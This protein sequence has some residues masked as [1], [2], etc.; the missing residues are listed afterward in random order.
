MR[1]LYVDPEDRGL[2]QLTHAGGRYWF[3]GSL[4]VGSAH[5]GAGI[6]QSLM[7][8]V[9]ADADREDVALALVIEPDPRPGTL[10]AGA[11]FAWY[12]RLG[13]EPVDGRGGAMV[14]EPVRSVAAP[15]RV[16][17]HA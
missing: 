8:R 2:V 15:A 1:N 7:K 11:L 9:C 3:I 14:R 4:R 12:R 10:S 16:S 6:G 5:R 17:V 13:F